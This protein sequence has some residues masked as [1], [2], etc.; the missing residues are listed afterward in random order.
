MGEGINGKDLTQKDVYETERHFHT[1]EVWF[2]LAGTPSGETHRADR[3]IDKPEPFQL[4]AENNDY[5]SWVQ[6]LGSTDT[7]FVSGNT[8]YDLHQL[9]VASHERNN[10]FHNVQI[11]FGESAELAANLTSG[12]Y[13]EAPFVTPSAPGGQNEPIDFKDKRDV[14]LVKAW[15]RVWSKGQNTGTVDLYFGLHEYIK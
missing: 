11:C 4:D 8:R 7:P 9:I 15:A 1:N 2:G 10:I 5:G 6:I 3:L 13:T 12:N 14:S